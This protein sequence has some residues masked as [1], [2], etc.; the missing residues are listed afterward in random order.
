[1]PPVDS[2]ATIVLLN[3]WEGKLEFV[4]L[5]LGLVLLFSVQKAFAEVPTCLDNDKTAMDINNAQVIDWKDTTP[6]E[7]H[8]RGNVTGTISKIYPNE[9]G[10]NHFELQMGTDADDYIEI[11]YDIEFGKLPKLSEGMSVQACGDYIT[12]NAP[13]QSYSAS[14]DGAL[15]HWVHW[16]DEKKHPSGFLMINGEE[17]GQK[18]STPQLLTDVL[19]LDIVR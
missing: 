11:I 4:K 5:G 16:S 6:N 9:T 10:H 17:Y 15:I 8:N 14:P 1:L 7:Y 12:S 3:T 2:L 13:Y 18:H 19:N